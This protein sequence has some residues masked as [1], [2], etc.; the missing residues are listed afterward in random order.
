MFY[1]VVYVLQIK[2]VDKCTVAVDG[3]LYKLH[4]HFKDR[5]IAAMKEMEPSE[6]LYI[7][8]Y[9]EYEKTLHCRCAKLSIVTW[10]RLAIC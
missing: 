5:M 4:P 6:C 7:F 1:D 2:K 3:S 9:L 10:A 8:C